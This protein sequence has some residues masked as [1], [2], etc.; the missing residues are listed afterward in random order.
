MGKRSL[1]NPAK[2][3]DYGRGYGALRSDEFLVPLREV[4]RRLALG[5]RTAWDIQRDGLKTIQVGRMKYVRAEDLK[6]YFDALAER[7]QNP[8]KGEGNGHE[9]PE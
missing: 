1:Q 5:R 6:A 4:C 9:T 8:R 7:Q 3:P 2:R